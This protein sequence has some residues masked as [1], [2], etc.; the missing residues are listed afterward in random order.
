MMQP[1][2]AGLIAEKNLGGSS[3]VMATL[4]PETHTHKASFSGIVSGSGKRWVRLV[5]EYRAV[6]FIVSAS[7]M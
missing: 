4:I 1:A 5:T 6:W 2:A 7:C 3:G